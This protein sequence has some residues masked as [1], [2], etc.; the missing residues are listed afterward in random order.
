MS[1]TKK[2]IMENQTVVFIGDVMLQ[3]FL[4]IKVHFYKGRLYGPR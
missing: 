2:S 3:S 4:L 1:T